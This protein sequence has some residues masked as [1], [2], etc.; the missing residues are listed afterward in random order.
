[1]GEKLF[2]VPFSAL[3]YD[4]EENEYFLDVSKDR[5]KTAPGFDPNHWPAMSD[6]KWNREVYKFY[7]RSPYWE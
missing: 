2:A 3:K 4:P 5:F 6:D 1:M 7:E